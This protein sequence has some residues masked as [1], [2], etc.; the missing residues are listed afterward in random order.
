MLGSALAVVGLLSYGVSALALNRTQCS[1]TAEW[2]GW[3][4]LKYA[5]IFGDSYTTTGFNYTLTPAPSA[6]NPLGN[7]A[8]PG[9]TASNGPNWV[10]Y[11]TV[12]YNSSLLETFNLAYGGATVSS[13]LVAPYLPTVLSVQQ[14]VQSEF[15]PGYTG[16]APTAPS[17]PAWKGSDTLFAI[18]IG[19]NDVGNSYGEGANASDALNAEIFDVYSGLV[20]QLYDAGGRNFL[21]INVPPVDR[22][23][24]TTEQGTAAS[25]LEKAD[26]ASWNGR[27]VDMAN[28]LKR[29]YTETNVWYF[30]ANAIFNQVLDNPEV[31]PQ[32]AD[33]KNTTGY[34]IA[35]ENGTPEPDTFNATCG[36]P[37]NE[38]F[39]LNTLHPTYPMH[40]VVAQHISEALEAEPN[41]C[42]AP[43]RRCWR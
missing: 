37:V 19:I 41:V 11:L 3:K 32:T 13:A 39:W 40:D 28:T 9:Y 2:P 20:G 30:D 6:S 7:P 34:C 36:V 24:L 42:A 17:A 27:V 22:A 8:Y 35:Y 5:F 23:P 4:S 25:A 10:D 33:Y 26:I 43:A 29:N 31:Y 14:Q 38:Y 1:A 21:F 15:I 16:E 18:W 12:Q